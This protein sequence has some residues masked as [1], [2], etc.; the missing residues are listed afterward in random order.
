MRKLTRERSELLRVIVDYS[1]FCSSEGHALFGPD[2]FTVDP[3]L[4]LCFP[5]CSPE[6]VA[7]ASVSLPP[8]GAAPLQE[9]SR[10]EDSPVPP[11][12]PSACTTAPSVT[13]PTPPPGQGG[14]QTQDV[15]GNVGGA[16]L[17][18]AEGGGGEVPSP[19]EPP[20]PPPSSAPPILACAPA[21]ADLPCCPLVPPLSLDVSAAPPPS[22]ED[23]PLT[24]EPRPPGQGAVVLQQPFATPMQPSVGGAKP[25]SQPQ[26]PA[27]ATPAPSQQGPGESDGEGPP[28]LEFVDSTIKTLDEKLRNLLYQ[29]HAP[30]PP[31]GS[32]PDTASSGT[33]FGNSP[34]VSD[35]QAGERPYKKGDPLV[36]SLHCAPLRWID[37]HPIS[38]YVI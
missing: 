17:L 2:A 38:F 19:D 14:A 33:E 7:D 12:V 3:Q 24:G 27:Q 31:A 28:R 8:E 20:A 18:G 15:N 1:M 21:V 4:T 6:P 30:S 36:I 22:A 26:S 35:G 5:H 34:P 9:S 11:H 25:A 23:P 37:M 16:K 29:E 13:G 10:A 32:A